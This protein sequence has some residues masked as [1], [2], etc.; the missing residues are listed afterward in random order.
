MFFIDK[1]I[2]QI[3]IQRENEDFDPAA[4]VTN[5]N[6]K[7]MVSALNDTD[8]VRLDEEKYRKQLEKTK[9]LEKENDL[10][11]EEIA[12]LKGVYILS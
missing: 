8:K 1:L 10:L 5:I 2:Q 7:S 12:S 6:V 3:V 9:R 11:K 4:A